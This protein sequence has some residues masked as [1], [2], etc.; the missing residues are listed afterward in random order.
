M[1]V[2]AAL[3]VP[4]VDPSVRSTNRPEIVMSTNRPEIVR[5]TNRPEIVRSTNRP[6]VSQVNQ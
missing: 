3:L 4:P 6:E 2:T 1:C 5:S